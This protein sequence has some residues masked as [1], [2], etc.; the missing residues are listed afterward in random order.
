MTVVC[1]IPRLGE[2]SF[3]KMV[4]EAPTRT[5]VHFAARESDCERCDLTSCQPALRCF[6]VVAETCPGLVTR[7]SIGEYPTI[8]VFSGGRVVRR[9][10]GQCLPGQVYTI[11][12]SEGLLS[13]KGP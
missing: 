1:R 5:L 7:Y 10:I 13:R 11:L 9:L 8:L 3:D 6:C 2:A 4:L 12:Q